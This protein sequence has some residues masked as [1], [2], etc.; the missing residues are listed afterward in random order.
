MLKMDCLKPYYVFKHFEFVCKIDETCF[1]MLSKEYCRVISIFGTE[2]Y[3]F[4]LSVSQDKSN[5]IKLHICLTSIGKL[6]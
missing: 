2:E 4:Y 3:N 6:R 1:K 5:L